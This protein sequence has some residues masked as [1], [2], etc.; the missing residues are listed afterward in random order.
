MCFNFSPLPEMRHSYLS[1]P[2]SK[3]GTITVCYLLALFLI[4]GCSTLNAQLRVAGC[5]ASYS[6]VSYSECPTP[7]KCALLRI[8]TM[9]SPALYKNPT[10]VGAQ[11]DSD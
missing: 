9:R 7:Y 11:V 1:C 2:T 5:P 10:P 4:A 8:S 6:R 3:S